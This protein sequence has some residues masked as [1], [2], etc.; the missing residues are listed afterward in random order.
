MGSERKFN[1]RRS[2]LQFS[3]N[4]VNEVLLGRPV[5]Q[6]GEPMAVSLAKEVLLDLDRQFVQQCE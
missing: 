2:S 5:G 6:F 1:G 4:E 3:L